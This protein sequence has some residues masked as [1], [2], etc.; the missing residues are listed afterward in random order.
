MQHFSNL[1]YTNIQVCTM[2]CV[3]QHTTTAYI[4]WSKC[5]PRYKNVEVR[6]VQCVAQTASEESC[7]Q[8]QSCL[9]CPSTGAAVTAAHQCTCSQTFH[10][11]LP[12]LDQILQGTVPTIRKSQNMCKHHCNVLGFD[13]QQSLITTHSLIAPSVHHRFPG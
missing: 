5:L 9:A 10:P 12:W 1:Y 4:S 11:Q 6:A 7:R 13:I 8:W 3:F 2:Y